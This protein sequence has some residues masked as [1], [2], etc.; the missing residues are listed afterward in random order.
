M[1]SHKIKKHR[2]NV[3]EKNN[4]FYY[5]YQGD[6]KKIEIGFGKYDIDSLIETLNK[7][8]D[9]DDTAEARLV[10]REALAGPSSPK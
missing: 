2:Y 4:K 10:A 9:E 3:T 5:E 8:L 7:A 6:G 1:I